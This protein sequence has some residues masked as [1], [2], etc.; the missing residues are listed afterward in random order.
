MRGGATL[1]SFNNCSDCNLNLICEG[2]EMVTQNYLEETTKL[3]NSFA[4]SN[5]MQRV[6]NHFVHKAP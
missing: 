3:A 1:G 2:L 5:G 6:A 4:F